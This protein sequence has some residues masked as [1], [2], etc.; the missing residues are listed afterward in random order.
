MRVL[1]IMRQPVVAATP[2]APVRDIASQLVSNGISG[3]PVAEPDGTVIGVVSEGDILRTLIEGRPLETLT[4]G[5]IMDADPITVD[6]ETPLLD[7]M[8]LLHQTGVLRLPVTEQGKL[9]G[10]ISRSDIIRAVADVRSLQA[11]PFITFG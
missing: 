7:A 4:A 11:L 3:M 10:V 1:Q 9:V 8:K 2:E 6:A 5:D